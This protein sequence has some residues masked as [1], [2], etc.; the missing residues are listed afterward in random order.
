MGLTLQNKLQIQE[1][2]HNP[3]LSEELLQQLNVM[4]EMIHLIQVI[5][6]YNICLHIC[7]TFFQIKH[8]KVFIYFCL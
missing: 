1:Q 8:I 3:K 5:E 6:N 4:K 2:Q 7:M